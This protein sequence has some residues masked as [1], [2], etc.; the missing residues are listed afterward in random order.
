M[1][2]CVS[3]LS[4]PLKERVRSIQRP[5]CFRCLET[6]H[7]AEVY[8]KPLCEYGRGKH[9]SLLHLEP[10]KSQPEEARSK[11]SESRSLSAA[12]P[13]LSS[14]VTS[15]IA[16][17][18]RGKVIRQTVPAVFCGSN[19]CKKVVRCFFDPGS[20][21]SFVKPSVVADLGL[22]GK[23]VGIAVSGF[24]KKSAK[25]TLR[26]RISFTLAPVGKPGKPQGAE[27]LTAPV[28]WIAWISII[29]CI[30]RCCERWS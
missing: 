7:R 26:K 20:Q 10:V 17:N 23:T 25:D 3:F 12:P 21:T 13:S 8:Q 4:L 11:S 1:W 28:I 22:D 30:Q 9:H 2:S 29:P 5:L 19:G 27:A 14:I 16:V 24:G 6:G 18:S 15:S